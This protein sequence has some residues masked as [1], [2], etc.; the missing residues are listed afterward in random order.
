MF[1]RI[2]MVLAL[3]SSAFGQID[4]LTRRYNDERNGVNDRETILTQENVR[5]RFGKLW[6]LYADGKI[7]AQPLYVSNL[8][9]PGKKIAGSTAQRKCANGCNAVIFAT[10]KGSVYAYMAD[11][12]PTSKDD[13]LLWSTYLSD[14]QNCHCNA[15]GPQLGTSKV[16]S[17]GL[18]DPW[19]GIL[20]T[21]VIDRTTNS[22]FVID[23]TNDQQYRLYDLNL[24][25]GAV[26]KGPV[27]VDGKVG[28]QS[29][30]PPAGETQTARQR[31]GLLLSG[32]L[33]Y[34]AF[35]M[36][37][38]DQAG[39]WLFVYDAATLEL[40]TVWSPTPNGRDGGIWMSG[41]GPSVDDAGNIYL[42]TGNG[43][44]DPAKNS[45]GDSIVK[46]R[47]QNGAMV[48][49]GFFAPCN[50]ALLKKCDLDQG[51][52]GAVLFG[53]SVLGAGKDGKLFLMHTNQMPG[54][55]ADAAI[56]Q[57]G[58]CGS[59]RSDCE[60]PAALTQKWQVTKEKISG[61]P[62]V[63]KGPRN[64]TWL[65]VMA[66]GDALKAY[67]WKDGKFDVQAVTRSDFI[68]P[69]LDKVPSCQ[70]NEHGGAWWPGGFIEVSSDGTKP[71]TGIVW[72][73]V[74]ANGDSNHCRGVKGM[75]LALNAEDITQEL[76]RSQGQDANLTDTDNSFGLLPRFNLPTIANGKV[77]VSTAGDSEPLRH[78]RGPRPAPGPAN[79][80]LT[81]YGLK[82]PA[83]TAS[84]IVPPTR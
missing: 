30:A 76:W 84:T 41:D 65:Y 72:A 27:V 48:L 67:P 45:Y 29:F 49:E 60:E 35:G 64:Q 39:G 79:Y 77:F 14:Q 82:E 40:K 68:Q 37:N 34:A 2:L 16:E 66:V 31:A 73:L 21:P 70:T 57:S 32:G 38:P 69:R 78:Y 59:G 19:W 74:P 7:M 58:G 33:L 52:T 22:L 51:S 15:T 81:V 44:L 26:Q 71:G 11:Q 46:L 4:V 50:Q 5:S 36:D 18:D 55:R 9:V 20:S 25:T 3:V 83:Q 61:A 47:Y 53:D 8:R 1:L 10:M 28:S 63:W 24:T 17:E 12:R 13:T 54:Y 75:L 80:Y 43:V 42:Q 56:S 6:T 23:W 62:V